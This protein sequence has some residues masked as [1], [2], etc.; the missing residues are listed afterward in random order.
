MK[1]KPRREAAPDVHAFFGN[2]DSTFALL[3]QFGTYN[4]QP[5]SDSDNL[6]P[7]IGPA[8]PA[9]WRNMALDQDNTDDLAP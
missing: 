5:T 3:N 2:P 7:L 9:L 6:F 4:I 1:R 8:L